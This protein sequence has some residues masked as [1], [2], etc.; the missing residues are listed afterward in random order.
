MIKNL[1]YNHQLERLPHKN[2]NRDL[3]KLPVMIEICNVQLQVDTFIA[4]KIKTVNLISS[5]YIVQL[6]YIM[7]S[8][9]GILDSQVV[10]D[11]NTKSSFILV[12]VIFILDID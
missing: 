1:R 6:M 9:I 2:P 7:Q 10:D 12:T 3:I 4:S 11:Q 5:W 8:L